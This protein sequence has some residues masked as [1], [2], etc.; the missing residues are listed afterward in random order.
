MRIRFTYDGHPVILHGNSRLAKV[1][2]V[3][4]ITFGSHVFLRQSLEDVPSPL[5]GH[6]IGH[7]RQYAALG[8][9]RFFWRYVAEWRQH[10]YGLAMPLE[11]DAQ[12][13]GQA[14][15]GDLHRLLAAQVPNR[16]AA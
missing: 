7:V 6:E 8:W 16:R 1:L 15:W 13:Y 14:H 9:L 5:V 11:A 10:G 4:G 2:G 3:L 12:T